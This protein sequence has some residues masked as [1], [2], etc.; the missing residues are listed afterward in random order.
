MKT[1]VLAKKLRVLLSGP[2]LT[3][4]RFSGKM[5]PERQLKNFL[6]LLPARHPAAYEPMEPNI[7]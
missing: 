2:L 7:E 5:E 1:T 6:K 4:G 3:A